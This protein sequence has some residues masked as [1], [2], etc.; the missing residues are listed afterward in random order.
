MVERTLKMMLA[1]AVFFGLF[2]VT[3][4]PRI[5]FA[6]EPA[7]RP[8]A[9]RTLTGD[10]DRYQW[11][12]RP[13]LVFAPSAYDER[14][15]SFYRQAAENRAALRDRQML[16]LEVLPA[17]GRI[18]PPPGIDGPERNEPLREGEAGALRKRF[19][20]TADDF[21]MVLVGKDGGEKHRY[22]DPDEIDLSF[23]DIDRMPMRQREMRSGNDAE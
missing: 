10:L 4:L 18:D 6:D 11:E 22:T 3:A 13:L 15:Q 20:V 21:V 8:Q 19:R 7:A 9:A 12:Y 17:G 5:S 14:L 1:I 2:A 23:R 16:V